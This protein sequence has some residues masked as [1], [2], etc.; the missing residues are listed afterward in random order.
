LLLCAGCAAP[1]N[2]R[3]AIR[4]QDLNTPGAR[5]AAANHFWLRANVPDMRSFGYKR[6]A[7]AE[8]AVECVAS[9]R[10]LTQDLSAIAAQNPQMRGE[11]SGNVQSIEVAYPNAYD[12]PG[13][14]YTVLRDQLASRGLEVLPVD[15]VVSAPAYSRY[16]PQPSGELVKLDEYYAG[17]SDTGRVKSLRI[18]S[19]PGLRIIQGGGDQDV[20]T[21]DADLLR[22]LKADVVLRIRV[23]VGTFSGHATL[24]RGSAVHVTTPHVNGALY[25]DRS[26]CSEEWVIASTTK[27][28]GSWF[29]T[30]NLPRYQEA[31]RSMF[32]PF[33]AMAF[34][35][36]E[37]APQPTAQ[38][39]APG[40]TAR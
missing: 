25:A 20:A 2:P 7:I 24:E 5:S 32:P 35:S 27:Q 26:L 13:L 21:I 12:F 14:M 11:L 37:G 28:L 30:V 6:I 23:R 17:G 40:A 1:P 38:P 4:L 16:Q 34:D 8:F 31:L 9:K 19:L 36:A 15:T 18:Y 3:Q 33:I 22:D 39:G 10:E 29:V